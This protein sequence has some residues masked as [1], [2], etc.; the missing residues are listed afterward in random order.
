MYIHSLVVCVR[1]CVQHFRMLEERRRSEKDDASHLSDTLPRKKT[2]PTM[3]HQFS[4]STLGRSFPT[5]VHTHTQ[6]VT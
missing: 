3:T 2:T 4:C 5:K 1:L 6:M